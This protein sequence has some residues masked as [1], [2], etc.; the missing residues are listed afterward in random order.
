MTGSE[1]LARGTRALKQAGID[2]AGRDARRLMAF[3]LGTEPGRLTLLLPEPVGDEVAA[4]FDTLIQRRTEREPV[5]HLVGTRDFFGR[6]FRVTP[7]VLDPRPE[8]ETLIEAALAEPFDRVLDLGTGTGCILLTLLAETEGTMGTGV[9]LSPDALAVA[10]GNGAA[11]GLSERVNWA[12][13]DWFTGLEGQFDLIVSNPPY[14][15]ADEMPGLSRDVQAY[16][17]R[18]ALTDEGDGL[19]AYR[20]ITAGVMAHLVPG[21]RLAVEIGPTQA[22]AVAAMM[23]SAGLRGVSIVQDLDG[24]DRVLTARHPD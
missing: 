1:L 21:G 15:A 8:T 6:S 13:G 20:A 22:S 5:S 11:L 17:P 14:I 4:T 9:D 3:A 16:E 7:D 10:Q 19:S 18:M 24:R 2:G 12:A 23:T